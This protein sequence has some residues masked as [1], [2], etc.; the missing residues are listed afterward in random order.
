MNT[1]DVIIMTV[2]KAVSGKEEQVQQALRDV[3]AAA[4]KQPGCIEYRVFRSADNAST[5]VN[6]E[7]WSSEDEREAFL[8]G[9]EVKEFASAVAG[10]FAKSP[11][12]VSYVEIG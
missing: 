8:R 6:Y 4:R 5:T 10:G 3:A 7:R 11:Q 9:P 1:S 12:P 2:A